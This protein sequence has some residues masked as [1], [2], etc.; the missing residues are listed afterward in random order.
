MKQA[1][2]N[3]CKRSLDGGGLERICG[4][5]QLW[6]AITLCHAHYGVGVASAWFA[7]FSL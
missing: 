5:R 7:S 1:L 4:R 3:I 2:T 6:G